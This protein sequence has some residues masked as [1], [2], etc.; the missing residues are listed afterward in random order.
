M[1]EERPPDEGAS[2]RQAWVMVDAAWS[3]V[4]AVG[5]CSAGG[6]F[7][8]KHFGTTPW[9][10]VGGSLLGLAAGFTTFFRTVLNA[11]A[12]KKQGGTQGKDRS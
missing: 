8:D 5:L 6:Y 9:L 4:A 12:K 3:L 7:A 2:R 10:L 1:T 11:E